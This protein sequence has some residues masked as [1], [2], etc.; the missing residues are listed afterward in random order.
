MLRS[1]ALILFTLCLAGCSFTPEASA[2]NC[3]DGVPCAL[4]DREYHV[5]T[6]PGWDGETKLPVLLH[7]HGWGRRG[8]RVL[9]SKRV[10]EQVAEKGY[11]LVAPDGLYR[12]WQF[13]GYDDQD[14]VFTDAIFEDLAKRFPIDRDRIYVSGFS[15]GGAMAWR[16]ACN[17][18]TP[19]AGFFPIA[20]M[21]PAN[22]LDDCSRETVTMR[23]AHGLKDRVMRIYSDEG[24]PFST[25]MSPLVDLNQ[26][27]AT[28]SVTVQEAGH[29]CQ[30]WNQCNGGASLALCLSETG[31]RIPKNWIT[32]SLD[33]AD[34]QQASAE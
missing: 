29:E 5:R 8:D 27:S 31:H 34:Q 11:L 21:L 20:G 23:H 30:I 24:E 25:A 7:Y 32:H 12:S 4:G 9:T 10:G 26:C 14:I 16:Y 17:G 33:W 28:P 2:D 15:Y 6:P 13:R 1:T 18:E 19:V 3:G 22:S